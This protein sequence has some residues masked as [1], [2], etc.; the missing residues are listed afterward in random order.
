MTKRITETSEISLQKSYLIL[1]P[2]TVRIPGDERSRTNP[3]HGHPAETKHSWDVWSCGTFE[4]WRAQIKAMTA[5]GEDF[6]PIIG[7]RPEIKT[8]VVATIDGVKL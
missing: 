4:E 3:G 6:V 2:K 5:K 8:E 1:K 7:E